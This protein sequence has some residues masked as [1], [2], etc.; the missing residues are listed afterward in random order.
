MKK[1]ELSRVNLYTILRDVFYNAWVIILAVVAAFVGTFSYFNYIHKYEYTSTMTYSINLSGYTT[2]ATALTLARTVVIA[3]T[4]DDVF[5]S[6]AMT[7]VVRREIGD[8]MTG[9]ISARQITDTNL[10]VV[11]VT[12][13]SPEKAYDTLIAVSQN[14]SKVTDFVFNNVII[15]TMVNPQ[16]PVGPSRS[17][18]PVVM[19]LF[20]AFIAG[21]LVTGIVIVLSY[22]RDTVKN[23]S[24]IREELN[25]PLLGTVNRVRGISSKLPESK[26][27]LN[28]LNPLVG[29]DYVNSYQKIGV[30][31][32]SI[33]RRKDTKIFMLTSVTEH[34]GKTSA[35][36]NI[37]IQ[38]AQNGHRTLL[39]DCDLRRP[40]VYKFFQKV[41]RRD[42]SDFHTFLAKGGDV[43]HY[44]RHDPETGLFIL[45]NLTRCD[46]ASELLSSK[47]FADLI[48][49][50]REQF[51][52]IIV[53]TSPSGLTVD[54][55]IVSGVVDAAIFV[56]R[57]DLAWISD[58]TDRIDTINKC[59]FAGCIFND[60]TSLK[61]L[62]N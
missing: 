42:D 52:F 9:K 58:I 20:F 6:D 4:L 55:E 54:P 39:I 14:Y 22:V 8:E 43:T 48:G 41:T 56:V 1:F 25:V 60:V 46:N 13:E 61:S 38:L 59:Y 33:K 50:L 24:E 51:D 53:D 35:S 18:S 17:F 27:H 11:S 19:G 47:R 45:D 21:V 2:S 29:T 49:A 12:D 15:Q 3:E 7:E 36:V 34:E 5:Q 28:V 10:I 30:K 62:K 44:F 23:A 37:A 31:L 16:M 26:R 57:Q 40:S 32:E